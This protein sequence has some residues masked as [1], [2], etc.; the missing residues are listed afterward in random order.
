VR[1][2][3]AADFRQHTRKEPLGTRRGSRDQFETIT[4][5]RRGKTVTLH[6]PEGK[7]NHHHGLVYEICKTSI[8]GS[9]PGGASKTLTKTSSLVLGRHNRAPANG[10]ESHPRRRPL[11]PQVADSL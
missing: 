7:E 9:N 6:G 4:A 3:A 2:F 1:S 11:T 8:P 10:L 5:Q